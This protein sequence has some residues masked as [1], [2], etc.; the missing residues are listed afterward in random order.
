ME[1]IK[2]EDSLPNIDEKVLC[3]VESGSMSKEY[4]CTIALMIKSGRFSCEMDWVR[5]THWTKI[6]PPKI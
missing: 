5:V 3:Y 6:E 2:V 1:W 4:F